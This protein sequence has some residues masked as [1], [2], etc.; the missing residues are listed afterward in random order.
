[1]MFP[2]CSNPNVGVFRKV[3]SKRRGCDVGETGRRGFTKWR[4][5][6]VRVNKTIAQARSTVRKPNRSRAHS[7]TSG[8]TTPA[9]PVP[10]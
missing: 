5:G 3:K 8:K 10:A 1:M 9:M 2:V 4:R 6:A 7:M